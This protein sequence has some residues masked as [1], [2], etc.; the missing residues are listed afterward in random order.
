[1][2]IA[3]LDRLSRNAAVL[4]ALQQAGTTFVACDMPEAN[5]LVAHIFAAVAQAERTAISERTRAALMAAR[6]RGVRLGNPNLAPGNAASAAVASK[7]RTLKT[8][9]RANELIDVL[10]NVERQGRVTLRQ[11]PHYMNDLGIGCAG[12]GQWYP[13]S[14]STTVSLNIMALSTLLRQ[15]AE[16]VW[17]VNRSLPNTWVHWRRRWGMRIGWAR[18]VTTAAG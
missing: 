15:L 4:A 18:S 14:V 5:K 1:M 10:E 9:E 6:E 7:A 16:D 3:K 11:L 12:G 17:I 13:T 8:E 2:L